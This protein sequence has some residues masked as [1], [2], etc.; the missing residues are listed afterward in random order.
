MADPISWIAAKAAE[1]VGMQFFQWAT[2]AG[3]SVSLS[4][5][6]A[7]VAWFATYGLVYAGAFAG[8][9][10]LA[11]PNVPSAD[12]G[13]VPVNQTVPLRRMGTGRVRLSGPRMLWEGIAGWNIE[14]IY[15]HEGPIDGFESWWI[16]DDEVTLGAGGWVQKLD[17]KYDGEAI[18]ILHRTGAWDDE[19]FTE[20]IDLF[21]EAGLPE[22]YTEAHEG[23]GIAKIAVLCKA[24]AD[25]RLLETYPNGPPAV[26][27][28]LRA[29]RVYD[30]RDP[31]QELLDPRT[32]KW[33]QNAVVNHAHWEWCLRH[34]PVAVDGEGWIQGAED[35]EGA[36]LPP[37]PI[38]LE[39]W[40]ADILPRLA[41]WTFW[42][43]QADEAV[44]LKAGGTEPRY[45]QD[46]WWFI[47][48]EPAEIRKRFLDCYDGW[49]AEGADGALVV[50]GGG[51][52][53]PDY[54]LTDR[55]LIEAGWNRWTED[56]STYNVLTATFTSAEHGYSPQEAQSWRD[57]ASVSAIGE[58]ILPLNLEW[59]QS[60]GQARRLMKS[61]AARIFAERHG[62]LV[63]DLEGLNA[64][65]R[66]YVKLER[67]RGP[68]TMRDVVLEVMGSQV[69]LTQGRVPMAF[70]KADPTKHDWD[71]ATEE[72]DGPSTVDR[73]PAVQPPVPEILSVT[74]EGD[75][76]GV[77]LR[78]R[79]ADTGRAAL[80]YAPR[81]R[82]QDETDWVEEPPRPAEAE[83][84]D[85]VVTTGLVTQ[86]DLEA[87]VQSWS[88]GV[89]SAWSDAVEVDATPVGLIAD[90]T[91]PSGPFR[92]G[93]AAANQINGLA[94]WTYGRTGAAYALKS[95]GTLQTFA[96]NAPRITDRGLLIENAATNLVIRSQ[97]MDHGGWAKSAAGTGSAPV[98]T[99]NAVV[100][101]DGTTTADR[102][103]FNQ[104][105]GN[106]TADLSLITST[107]FTVTNGA[108]YTGSV[109][110]RADTPCSI[111][112]RHVG[113]ATFTKLD[114]TSDWQRF[115]VQ[116][117]SSGTSRNFTLGLR[118]MGLGSSLAA[119]VDVWNPQPEAGSEPT[120]EI[121]TTTAAATRPADAA[122]LI[123]PAGSDDDVIEV[124]H[125]G[126]TTTLQRGDLANPNLLDLGGASG[127]PWVGHFLQRVTVTP[128]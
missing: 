110:L 32:W 44:P 65:E 94:D 64:L 107:A 51:Y 112:M 22:L 77:R 25:K 72:G 27:A 71:P 127:R 56:R 86:G 29:S 34:L 35:G 87:A 90:L 9:A 41:E 85:L 3:L 128:A 58:K 28:T 73:A 20:I 109:W 30:W 99:A 40:E 5:Q 126:G 75:A 76:N 17:G 19:P 104:G 103:F 38:C 69:D 15:V 125:D 13:K 57:E 88:G 105:A 12:Q 54:V 45:R 14:I 113:N 84:D 50:H 123:L 55:N 2:A 26:S 16:H 42:A 119:T 4:A 21:A 31:E 121:L 115:D 95:D 122:T 8:A 111:L 46:G 52:V 7:N 11:A 120:S 96:A 78:L 66:R 70:V 39:A 24:V 108:I 1:W 62:D 81:W 97:E 36:P 100:A 43:D 49:M 114:V 98:V 93:V 82:A 18:R 74:A 91:F 116:E 80:T 63:V 23:R 33:G 92:V 117:T 89:P 53:A 67:Q 106:T 124:I 79:F 47:G 68:T 48:T 37:P 83:G 102:V 59:V 10:A 61:T 60:H 101:P 6:I 118:G